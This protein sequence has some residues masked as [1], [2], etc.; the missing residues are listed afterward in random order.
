MSPPSDYSQCA[1]MIRCAN[2]CS[3]GGCL[4]AI[5]FVLKPVSTRLYLTPASALTLSRNVC[6][7]TRER[8]RASAASGS[9]CAM[10]VKLALLGAAAAY[11]FWAHP[12]VLYAVCAVLVPALAFIVYWWKV[13]VRSLSTCLA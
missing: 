13:K 5:V 2:R 7:K 6:I 12:Y 4:V 1:F 10:S 8:V 3:A 11:V 9:L